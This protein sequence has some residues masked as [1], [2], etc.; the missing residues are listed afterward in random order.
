MAAYGLT[1]GYRAIQT[2]CCTPACLHA[3]KWIEIKWLYRK[4]D[5]NNQIIGFRQNITKKKANDKAS[6]AM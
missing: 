6:V 5:K 3:L 1:A 2:Q 4:N